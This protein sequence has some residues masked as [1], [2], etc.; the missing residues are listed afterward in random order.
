MNCLLQCVILIAGIGHYDV[1]L[2]K[3][4]VLYSSPDYHYVKLIQGP[5]VNGNQVILDIKIWQQV[6]KK[7]CKKD[8][9]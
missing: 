4:E 6:L 7:D 8:Q 1:C 2:G 5:L 9:K 3:V